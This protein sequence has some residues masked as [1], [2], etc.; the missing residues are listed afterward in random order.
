MNND[1][2]HRFRVTSFFLG[3]NLIV[4]LV[5]FLGIISPELVVYYPGEFGLRTFTWSFVHTEL[6]HL[7]FNLIAA[8]QMGMILESNLGSR[9]LI[10]VTILIWLLVSVSAYMWID[11]P[12]VGFSGV[13]MGWVSFGLLSLW[14]HKIFRQ[15]LGVWLGLN[16]IIGL[17]PGISFLGHVLG[18]IAGAV[19]WGVLKL[20]KK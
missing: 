12:L 1:F 8:M 17:L 5:L 14:K 18:M 7:I 20:L 16:I 6:T 3:L 19:V 10:F 13:L 4:F 11:Y 9:R 2:F 15:A